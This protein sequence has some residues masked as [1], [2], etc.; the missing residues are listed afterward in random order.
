MNGRHAHSFRRLIDKIGIPTLIVTDVDATETVIEDEK[1]KQKSEITAKGKEYK[2]G[3]PSILNWL[4]GK[5]LI[6]D[7]LAL[8]GKKK[9]V[10]NVRIAFQ[11]PISVKWNKEK[12]EYEE[13]CPYT[14]EDALIFT[15][16]EL[17]RQDGLKKMRAIT[18]IANLLKKST[19]AVDLQKEIFYKLESKSSFKKADFAISLLYMKDFND[20]TA[21]AYIQ[22]GLKWLKEILDA[23]GNKDGK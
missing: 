12:E 19:S 22:E 1:E 4:P 20:L 6:D 11:T 18:T 15:N 9:I 16:L 14:F 17:F 7:L 2:T 21:P 5:E 23:N 3:N 10:D 8:D 13:I